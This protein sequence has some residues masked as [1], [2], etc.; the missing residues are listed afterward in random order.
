[1]KLTPEK[2]LWLNVAI[3][4]ALGLVSEIYSLIF[5]LGLIQFLVV[6]AF[7]GLTYCLG[8]ITFPLTD[9]FDEVDQ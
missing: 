7:V 4:I 8:C 6:W 3:I 2:E 9:G 1:M 5:S